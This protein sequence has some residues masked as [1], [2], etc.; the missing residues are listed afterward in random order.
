MQSAN[1]DNCGPVFE[2]VEQ[3]KKRLLDLTR[4]NRLLYL[5]EA[6]AKRSVEITSPDIPFLIDTIVNK[7]RPLTFPMSAADGQLTLANTM[8]TGDT[9][10]EP[11]IRKGDLE[12]N[13][14]I[15]DLSRSL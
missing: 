6:K 15:V 14:P 10:E 3:W 8:Q 13:L 1:V 9:K 7:G 4:R 12:T 5:T 2:K 11:P